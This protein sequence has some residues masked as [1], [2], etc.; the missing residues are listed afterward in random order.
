MAASA[1]NN[2]PFTIHSGLHGTLD[3]DGDGA[4]VVEIIPYSFNN[5]VGRTLRMAVVAHP[6]NGRPE[7]SSVAVKVKV[8]P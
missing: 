2:Y 7:V 1:T 5:A 8:K 6:G 4:A 3:P